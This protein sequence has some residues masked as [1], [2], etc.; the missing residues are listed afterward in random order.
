MLQIPEAV[1]AEYENLTQAY[2]IYKQSEQNFMLSKLPVRYIS[3]PQYA[4][5]INVCMDYEDMKE[6]ATI[7][8]DVS[9]AR[10][11]PVRTGESAIGF[12]HCFH[13]A[14]LD[15]AFEEMVDNESQFQAV[16]SSFA[17]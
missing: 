4:E 8:K 1:K 15:E 11:K 3:I 7:A 17:L 16:R 14:V 13:E 9:V 10:G 5:E 6:L 12:L 2:Y